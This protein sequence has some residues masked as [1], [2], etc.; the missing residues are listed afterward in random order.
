MPICF[1]RDRFCLILI[2]RIGLQMQYHEPKKLVFSGVQFKDILEIC[3]HLQAGC[4]IKHARYSLIIMRIPKYVKRMPI[5]FARDRVCAISIALHF[6]CGWGVYCIDCSRVSYVRLI[7]QRGLY[8]DKIK[9]FTKISGCS[10][11]KGALNRSKFT[12]IWISCLLLFL[13][14]EKTKQKNHKLHLWGSVHVIF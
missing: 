3:I 10:L 1:A 8:V 9:I 5:C 14:F 12:V 6:Y 13:S 4:R 7:Y 2:R 11:Y